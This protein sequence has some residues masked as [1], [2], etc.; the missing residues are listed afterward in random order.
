MPAPKR[1]RL[2]PEAVSRKQFILCGLLIFISYYL[3]DI[4]L[5]FALF[6]EGTFSQQLLAPELHEVCIR[7]LSG[8]ALAVGLSFSWEM[9]R[10]SE[11]EKRP[12]QKTL[13]DL[14]T[15]I[16]TGLECRQTALPERQ[17]E[18]NVTPGLCA[19]ADE[20]ILTL[21]LENLVCNAVKYSA[22]RKTADQLL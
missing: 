5:D 12:V 13:V 17:F 7:L 18:F 20:N 14:S 4:V 9:L 21:A 11:L 8:C 2:A 1:N 3:A 22:G 6:D 16:R 15:L 10:L 19:L